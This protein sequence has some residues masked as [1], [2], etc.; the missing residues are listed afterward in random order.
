MHGVLVCIFRC[1]R[2]YTRRL[3]IGLHLIIVQ[4]YVIKY[5]HIHLIMRFTVDTVPSSLILYLPTLILCLIVV[6]SMSGWVGVLLRLGYI[7]LLMITPYL[8]W[9]G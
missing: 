1:V 2:A 6:V 7:V 9:N 4:D 3:A 8:E 5:P